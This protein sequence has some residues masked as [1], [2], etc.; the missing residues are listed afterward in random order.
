MMKQAFLFSKNIKSIYHNHLFN[1]NCK[2]LAEISKD[3]LKHKLFSVVS[4]IKSS[5][6]NNVYSKYEVF[7]NKMDV[8]GFNNQYLWN[9]RSSILWIFIGTLTF[10]FIHPFVSIIPAWICSGNMLS[11]F[12]TNKFAK[13]LVYKIILSK[14]NVN[15]VHIFIALKQKEIVCEIK[16]MELKDVKEITDKNKKKYIVEFEVPNQKGKKQLGKIYLDFDLNRI[17]NVEIFKYILTAD[18]EAV[19]NMK[20]VEKEKDSGLKEEEIRKEELI[21]KKNK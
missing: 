20:F 7:D 2:F 21:N 16:K 8:I 17:E 4:C 5:E 12:M 13:N 3:Q 19:K 18:A 9:K 6:L 10:L 15:L 11:T 14:E 1:K